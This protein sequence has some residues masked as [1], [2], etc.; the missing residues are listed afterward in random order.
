MNDVDRAI[1]DV[2]FRLAALSKVCR[3]SGEQTT[4]NPMVCVITMMVM[5]TYKVC[6][7]ALCHQIEEGGDVV[8][9]DKWLLP[10]D[11]CCCGICGHV[12]GFGILDFCAAFQL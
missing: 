4:A 1:S 9:I 5:M 11:A 8:D 6:G 12:F 7:L 2:D 10:S 3:K